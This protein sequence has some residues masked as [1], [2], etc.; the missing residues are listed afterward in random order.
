VNSQP[1]TLLRASI[2]DTEKEFRGL[3]EAW[4]SLARSAGGSVFLQHEWFDAAWAWREQDSSLF[5]VLAW[6][7]DA[8]IGILPLVKVQEN[9]RFPASRNLEFLAVPDTQC[10][11]LIAAPENRNRV[12]Q[13]FCAELHKRRN[14]WDQ[15]LL[16]YLDE[17]AA[18]LSE[19]KTGMSAR[20]Y[21]CNVKTQGPNLFVPLQGSWDSY[22]GTRSRSLKKANNLAANRL[23]KTGDIRVEWISPQNSEKTAIESAVEQAIDISRRSWK[24]Q[25]GN[26][27]NQPGPMRFITTLTAH[28]ARRGWLSLWLLSI[29]GRC[30]AM[31][32]QLLDA[33]NVYAL[34]ADF[35]ADCE[36]ISPGSHLMRTLL[37]SLFGR[38]LQRYYMG[39]GENAYKTRWT[40]EG[41]SL[42]QMI[43]HGRTWRGR[44]IRFLDDRLK[45]FARSLR[46]T[47]A[48]RKASAPSSKNL[49][50]PVH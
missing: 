20:R 36:E 7:E 46:N 15:L 34:R 50:E 32:Y 6:D 8:L 19:I 33:D 44:L 30:L 11:D 24:Q 1:P 42:Y 45:P 10:C 26:S 27:L 3:A 28:A 47:L 22:Y 21:K 48:A 5:L 12:T 4:N 25:T 17:T 38:N 49:R 40:E 18:A 14:E 37:E 13:A 39:P 31:E 9:Q 43:V 41:D 23:K 2:V 35:D 29:D 16:R